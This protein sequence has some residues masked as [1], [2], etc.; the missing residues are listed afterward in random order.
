MIDRQSY[1]VSVPKAQKYVSLMIP[2]KLDNKFYTG[3]IENI[4]EI[5]SFLKIKMIFLKLLNV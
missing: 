1:F 5:I 3:G 2:F 4:T